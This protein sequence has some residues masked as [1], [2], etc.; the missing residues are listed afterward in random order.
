VRM[1]GNQPLERFEIF[2]AQPSPLNYL[3]SKHSRLS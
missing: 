3:G 1:L 2:S